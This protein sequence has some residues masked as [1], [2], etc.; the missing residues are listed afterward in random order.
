MVSSV[1]VNLIT[2]CHRQQAVR[3]GYRPA[4]LQEQEIHLLSR[5]SSQALETNQ[6]P[7]SAYE[8]TSPEVKRPELGLTTH[9]HLI[10]KLMF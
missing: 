7:L 10:T 8:G 5:M 1:T 6:L 2:R 4:T 9:H 3:M